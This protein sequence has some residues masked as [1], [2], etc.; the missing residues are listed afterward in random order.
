MC[1]FKGRPLVA[2]Y[3]A[4]PI[5]L[6]LTLSLDRCCGQLLSSSPS[7]SRFHYET[8]EFEVPL[9]H[10][11]YAIN[12]SFKIRYLFNDS[13][14]DPQSGH[15]PLFFY[16]GNEG[17]IET[18]A[19]NT[20]FMWELAQKQRACVVFAEHRY[21]GKS[22]P[23]GNMTFNTTQN[24][25]YLSVEQTLEDFVWLITSLQQKFNYGP[26]IAFGGSYGGMLSAWIR[27]KYPH[28][29][30]GALAASAPV[31][32]FDG[33]ISCDI[34][35]RITTSVFAT[36]YKNHTCSQNIRKSWDL[37]KQLASTEDGKKKLNGAFNFCKP[38]QSETELKQFTDY[39]EDVYV[40]LAMANYPY[41]NDFLN[42]L[43]QYPVRQF[44]SY[45]QN[46]ETGD[47]LLKSMRQAIDVYVNFTGTV[48][49]LNYDSAFDPNSIGGAAWDIQTCNQMV[50]PMCYTEE[51]MFPPREWNFKEYTEQC[52]SKFHLKPKLNDITVRYGGK[53]FRDASNIIFSNGLLDPW[54]G[55]GVFQTDSPSISIIIIPEGAHHLDLRSTNEKDPPSVLQARERESEIIGK[56]I[57]EYH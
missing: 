11:N 42:P 6:T 33:L 41:A 36:T 25:G 22:M 16:T 9:D 35:A 39:L 37:F 21:Y 8:K 4:I 19:Q 53:N 27:M 57:A 17:D 52:L 50:M 15:S 51:T 3:F 43:P 20:G 28:V 12:E 49:C 5:I 2:F 30:Y 55:G 40:N 38:I 24:Y 54:S 1:L 48:S 26:V 29:V 7:A 10:F 46:A 31:R 14:V 47:K 34:F 45:L 56:W 18:F 44:C 32:Q 23:F 13:Y